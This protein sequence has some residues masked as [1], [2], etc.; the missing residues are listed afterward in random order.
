MKT[1]PEEEE[2]EM[3]APSAALGLP[4]PGRRAEEEEDDEEEEEE[5]E[6]E[7]IDDAIPGSA[8]NPTSTEVLDTV[9]A[10]VGS[11]CSDAARPKELTGVDAAEEAV[12]EAVELAGETES[13]SRVLSLPTRALEGV[14]SSSRKM[15]PTLLSELMLFKLD[16][17]SFFPM[18]PFTLALKVEDGL[19]TK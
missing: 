5:D 17:C 6:E 15:P 14:V 2:G 9:V 13:E 11:R 18:R 19:W 16:S 10:M 8:P 7:D 1:K 4:A 3:E 12:D